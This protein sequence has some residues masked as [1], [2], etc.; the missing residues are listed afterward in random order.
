MKEVLV[1]YTLLG[2]YKAVGLGTQLG[3]AGV[4]VL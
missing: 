2:A 3:S 1:A 4:G